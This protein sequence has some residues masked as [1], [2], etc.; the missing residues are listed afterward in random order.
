MRPSKKRGGNKD[1]AR[2]A[3]MVIRALRQA[4][5]TCPIRYDSEGFSLLI[6]DRAGAPTTLILDN[7]YTAYR[8]APPGRRADAI[9]P[10]LR[11]VLKWSGFN[12][13]DIPAGDGVPRLLPR[14][15]KRLK[16]GLDDLL[17]GQGD[18]PRVT[19][20]YRVLAEHLALGL[21]VDFPDS[22]LEVSSSLLARWGLEPEQAF[23]V[24][25]DNLRGR[26]EASLRPLTPG[27]FVSPWEDHHDASRLCLTEVVRSCE[28]RGDYVAAV[29]NQ[30]A[31]IV[32]GL[33]D[34]PG[35]SILFDRVERTLAQPRALSGVPVRLQQDRWVP[36]ELPNGHPE[37][38]R[39]RRLRLEAEAGDY[40]CQKEAMDEMYGEK[41][42]P[43]F[44]SD[45]MVG[46]DLRTGL[47]FSN[48][49]WSEGV[50]ALL[51]RVEAICFT[52][53]GNGGKHQIVSI[54]EWDQVCSVVG[55][56]MTPAGLYPE[57]YRV[58]QF[59]SA[60]QLEAIGT[61]PGA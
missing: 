12:P 14:V 13:D 50:P 61:G 19:P 5:K 43:H 27:V 15:R 57:R 36:L 17:R 29:P 23:A 44:V 11:I 16:Y 21:A 6:E 53:Q 39:L 26:S 51:P 49:T 38:Q 56:L 31:L 47:M 8:A 55:D 34:G 18:P 52:R 1:R 46:R 59:P 30:N 42:P 35:L 58:E 7:S 54:V 3:Q 60:T 28:V 41:A 9:R 24:A 10:Y 20:P 45:Y 25:S 32:T 40:H 2:F 37:F 4:G 22:V 48:C 33:E